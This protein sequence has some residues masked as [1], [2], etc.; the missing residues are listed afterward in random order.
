MSIVLSSCAASLPYSLDYPMTNETFT[1]RDDSFTGQ[2]PSGWF[3]SIVD[4]LPSPV[5]VWLLKEDF[6]ASFSIEELNLDQLSRQR[7]DREGGK[8]LSQFSQAFRLQNTPSEKLFTRQKEFKIQGKEFYGYEI[9]RPS[10]RLRVVVFSYRQKYYEC[11]VTT[12]SG[13]SS[14]EEFK[15]LCTAQQ[16][17]L[18]TL[19]FK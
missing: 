2:V 3:P 8:L 11:I 12:V 13:T 9:S 10:E 19:V 4:T 1:S 18:S 16:T 15:R 17:V 14:D 6:S 7:V 5:K